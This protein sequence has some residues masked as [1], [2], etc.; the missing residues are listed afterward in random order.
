MRTSCENADKNK[1]E[2][3][4]VMLQ[5][6]DWITQRKEGFLLNARIYINVDIQTFEKILAKIGVYSEFMITI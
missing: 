3:N 6:L 2:R 5:R 1:T 4:T